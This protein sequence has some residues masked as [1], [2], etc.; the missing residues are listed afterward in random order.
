MR[1][2]RVTY[3]ITSFRPPKVRVMASW[4][5]YRARRKIKGVVCL[6]L[7]LLLLHSLHLINFSARRYDTWTWTSCSGLSPFDASCTGTLAQHVQIVVKTGGSEPQSRLRT[8]LTTLLSK[9]PAESVVLLSDME[10]SIGSHRVHDVYADV[11]EQE[12]AAYPEFALYDAQRELQRRGDD[13][14]SMSGGWDLAK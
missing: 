12:R 10:E 7:T 2:S 8:L 9:I 4:S 14:R 13:T 1:R 3:A 5:F 6:T 11:T